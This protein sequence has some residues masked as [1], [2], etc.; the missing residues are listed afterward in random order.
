MVWPAVSIALAMIVAAGSSSQALAWGSHYLVTARAIEN[1]DLGCL[2]NQVRVESLDEF[3]KPEGEELSSLFREY[4][5]WLRDRGSKRFTAQGFDGRRPDVGQFIH[6]ARLN[7]KTQF[8]MGS[9]SLPNEPQ[10]ALRMLHPNPAGPETLLPVSVGS[11]MQTGRVYLTYVDE[12][13]WFMDFELFDN[14]D[15][16]YGDRPYG[17]AH[18]ESDKAPFHMQF[19]FENW[20][21]KMFAG[22]ITQGMVPDRVELFSRLASLAFR[23][24][25]PYWGFR[26]A[27]WALHYIQDLGQP[28]HAKAVPSANW[29]Y[30][31]KFVVSPE[32]ARIKQETTQLVANRHYAYED[33]VTN[34]L[35]HSYT[36]PKMAQFTDL[37]SQLRAEPAFFS[38]SVASPQALLL[39]AAK[40]SAGHA[41]ALDAAVV[42]AMGPHMTED[43]GY[44]LEH[45]PSYQADAMVAQLNP[46]S[47]QALLTETGADFSHV[48]RATRS[49]LL[50]LP[51]T[52][53][54]R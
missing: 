48:G 49:L 27:A 41:A 11:Q 24:G 45:D 35:R 50:A 38:S 12:P 19:W 13:D 14:P 23:K 6:A 30:Y 31:A 32:K 34:A 18:T 15:Y 8:P 4:Y 40:F 36:D 21:V 52:P 46:Q 44:D 53:C 25:H 26:F 17:N 43:P 1:S 9:R 47:A 10:L 39:E 42:Q 37:A 22:E 33:F 3:V 29:F 51:Y 7:P 2:Q 20:L 28:Y 5:L 54:T 16:G